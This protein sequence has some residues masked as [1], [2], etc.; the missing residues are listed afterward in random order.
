MQARKLKFLR[1]EFHPRK[2][3]GMLFVS[4]TDDRGPY[5]YYVIRDG[6]GGD[7]GKD[8]TLIMCP[9]WERGGGR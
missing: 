2:H 4:G 5:K 1:I 3:Q 6:V 9:G 8:N 7:K